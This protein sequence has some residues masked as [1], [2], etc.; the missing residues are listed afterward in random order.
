MPDEHH[1][2]AQREIATP[3]VPVVDLVEALEVGLHGVAVFTAQPQEA[4][5]SPAL[6]SPTVFA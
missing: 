1:Q 4:S 6:P 2:P 5:Y 3:T